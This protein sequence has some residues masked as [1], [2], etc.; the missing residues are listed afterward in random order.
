MES[1][2]EERHDTA[3]RHDAEGR[4]NAFPP[5]LTLGLSHG[6]LE[7]IEINATRRFYREF[8]GVQTL[9]H[10]MP[11]FLT[12]RGDDALWSFYIACVEA[13]DQTHP[14]TR[15]NRWELV[16]ATAD[17]VTAAHEAAVR[18][19]DELGIKQVDPVTEQDGFP[20]FCLQDPDG[21]WWGVSNRDMS[22]FDSTFNNPHEGAHETG[23]S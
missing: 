14:Q 9:R 1:L 2:A 20:W 7:C 13:G 3:S 22:W 6:T 18:L 5:G 21:N 10:V 17:E 11:A 16:V 19:K 23:H 4:P 8:L 15:D 12:W